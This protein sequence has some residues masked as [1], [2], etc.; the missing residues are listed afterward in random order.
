MPTHCTNGSAI[1]STTHEKW[2][3]RD[4]V[5]H[6]MSKGGTNLWCIFGAFCALLAAS[7][8]S[9]PLPSSKNVDQECPSSQI[10]RALSPSTLKGLSALMDRLG[11]LQGHSIDRG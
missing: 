5:M 10:S 7:C 6:N 11:G 2:N 1:H 4:Q 3:R 9:S 8:S